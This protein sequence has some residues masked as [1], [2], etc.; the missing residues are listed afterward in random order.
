MHLEV[1]KNL[2]KKLARFSIQNLMNFWYR[3]Y[4]LLFLGLFFVV[5]GI[6]SYQW[7]SSLHRYQW[8]DERKKAY[9]EEYFQ[10]TDLRETQFRYLVDRL[11]ARAA[12]HERPM[13]QSRNIFTGEPLNN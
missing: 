8:D 10:E 13:L 11:R 12:S 4:K 9:V 7:Y 2:K 3:S 5:L 1:S 6:S